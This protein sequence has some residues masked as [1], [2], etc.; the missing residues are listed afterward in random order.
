M[1]AMGSWPGR[2]R[3]VSLLNFL[4]VDTAEVVQTVYGLTIADN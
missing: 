3:L 4:N 1:L 2:L